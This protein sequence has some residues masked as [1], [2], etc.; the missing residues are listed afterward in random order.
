[1]MALDTTE[2]YPQTTPEDAY[3]PDPTNNPIHP[4]DM[5]H[6]LLWRAKAH[7]LLCAGDRTEHE[8][9]AHVDEKYISMVLF[10]VI[11]TLKQ[12]EKTVDYISDHRDSLA[13]DEVFVKLK[14]SHPGTVRIDRKTIRKAATRLL[15][16]T[17]QGTAV[18]ENGEERIFHISKIS[19]SS[20]G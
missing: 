2:R 17:D 1:M 15:H 4:E 18:D 12:A 6:C 20:R 13:E 9:L 8:H 3:K 16:A 19:I 7:L 10:S 14:I 5:L 11:G